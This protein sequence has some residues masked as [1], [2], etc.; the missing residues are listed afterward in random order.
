MRPL[1]RFIIR[2]RTQ[3]IVVAVVGLV[4]QVFS[5][6][7]GA[8]VGLVTLRH[9]LGNG[10]LVLA[11]SLAVAGVLMGL[12]LGTPEPLVVFALF[13]GLPVLV[14]SEVLRRTTSQGAALAAG[15]LMGGAA[16]TGIHLLTGDPVAWWRETLERVAAQPF[17]EA[18]P[19][20]GSQSLEQL[21]QAMDALA[22]VMMSL[23]TAAV[24]GAMLIVWLARWMHAA[25]DNPGG[26][27]KEFRSLRLDRRVA[28]VGLAMAVL[29]IFA[30]QVSGGLFRG[31]L[32]LVVV[33]YMIQGIAIIHAMVRERGASIGWLAAMY[34]ALLLVPPAAM[35]GLAV[36]GFSDTWFD[37]RG[38]WGAGT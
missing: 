8:V 37:F 5:F 33:L 38:R 27:G 2:G 26:F 34:L 7:S 36:T 17:R 11:A 28:F 10:A 12:V 1:L 4:S 6:V 13:T 30:G 32:A 22:P 9:G 29:A 25:L 19:D 14:L 3:A 21:E 24:V 15:G 35:L 23:P 18:N 31:L 16:L 20:L